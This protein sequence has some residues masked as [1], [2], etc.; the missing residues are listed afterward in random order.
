MDPVV[1]TQ[2]G[3]IRGL[4][5]GRIAVF[6]GV[7]YAA[8]PVGA[9]RLLPCREPEG[10]SGTRDASRC[11]PAAVQGHSALMDLTGWTPTVPDSEDCLSLNVFTP[12]PD[13]AKRPVF[14]WIHGGGLTNGTGSQSAYDGTALARKGDV[15]V[16]SLNYRLGALGF[17]ALECL[18]DREGGTMGNLGLMDQ[19]A[20]LEWIRD[21]IDRFGGDPGKVTIAGESAGATSVAALMAAPR[22]R[23][24]FRHAILQSGHGSNTSWPEAM[25][26][27]GERFMREAGLAAND[28]DGLLKLPVSAILA[29]QARLW[30]NNPDRAWCMTF[31]PVV[32][33]CFVEAMPD[34]SI[35]AGRVADKAVLAGTNLDEMKLYILG[36]SAAYQL[37]DDGLVRR[38]DRILHSPGYQ[39]RDWSRPVLERYRAA[40]PGASS[41]DLW[42]AMETDRRMRVPLLRTLELASEHARDAFS[43]LFTWPSLAFGGIAGSSHTT[44]IPFVFGTL[45]NDWAPL[46]V[47]EGPEVDHLCDVI[48]RSWLAFVHTGSP[49][50]PEL[51]GWKGYVA[52]TRKTAILGA[53]CRVERAP[54]EARRAAWDDIETPRDR[55]TLRRLGW[56]AAK[57]AD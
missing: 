6:R 7:P 34:E 33:G 3:R 32:D 24:L 56:A 12:G 25:L 40:M 35:R 17:L 29:A 28:L 1:E 13:N 22:A 14:V 53:E 26:D 41:G 38:L 31:Q 39:A 52:G 43:Y 23:P 21:N 4:R 18:R 19:V 5:E 37:D 10:W 54:L 9:L 50:I 48:Q 49:E 46:L 57:D 30:Q 42:W 44:E 27:T 45:H 11:G 55:W 2:A 16:V 36:D 47:G 8:A 15:V 51:S 20:A